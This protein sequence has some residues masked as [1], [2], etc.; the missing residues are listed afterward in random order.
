[1]ASH[2]GELHHWRC[3]WTSANCGQA[4]RTTGRDSTAI[5]PRTRRA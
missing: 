4:A 3:L 1:M 2:A 5:A